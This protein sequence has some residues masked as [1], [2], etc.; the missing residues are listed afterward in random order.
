MGSNMLIFTRS[1]T[2]AEVCTLDTFTPRH[3]EVTFH[4]TADVEKVTGRLIRL[5]LAVLVL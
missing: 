4:R 3:P 2:S 5:K 1:H